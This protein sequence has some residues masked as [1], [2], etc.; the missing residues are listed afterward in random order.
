MHLDL[1]IYTS[2]KAKQSPPSGRL[3]GLQINSIQ[4]LLA[5]GKAFL[6]LILI[7]SLFSRHHNEPQEKHG[8]RSPK[9]SQ[10]FSKP[11]G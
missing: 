3:R 7:K 6:L 8:G 1:P 10:I 4:G 9:P 11:E 2:K 5:S